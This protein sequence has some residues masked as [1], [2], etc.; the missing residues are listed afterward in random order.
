MSQYG[1]CRAEGGAPLLGV[2]VHGEW[3]PDGSRVSQGG[4]E[5]VAGVSGRALIPQA[6]TPSPALLESLAA[7][8]KFLSPPLP[9]PTQL[10]ET[11][12]CTGEHKLPHE[13]HPHSLLCRRQCW[14]TSTIGFVLAPSSETHL[15]MPRRCGFDPGQENPWRE[16]ATHFSILGKSHGEGLGSQS[17]GS[18][19]VAQDLAQQQPPPPP[20]K[21]IGSSKDC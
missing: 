3:E 15:S 16:I 6:T 12:A 19:S 14:S 1:W 2:G 4:L 5:T 10:H 13:A 11:E 7:Y 8:D 17:L 20:P 21:L 18:Q 9:T